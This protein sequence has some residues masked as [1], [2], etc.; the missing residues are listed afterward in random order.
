M[1]RSKCG[2]FSGLLPRDAFD[3]EFLLRGA[4]SPVLSEEEKKAV[5]KKIR[6][7]TKKDF[8]VKLGSV[9]LP[10]LREYYRIHKFECLEQRLS[11]QDWEEY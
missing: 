7:F 1:R 8:D 2:H 5:L 10:R 9:L 6:A 11:F 4:V 3:I